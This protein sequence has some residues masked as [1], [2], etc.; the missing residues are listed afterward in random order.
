MSLFKAHATGNGCMRL[1]LA[2]MLVQRNTVPAC[3]FALGSSYGFLAFA[4][5]W[6]IIGS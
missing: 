5:G 1:I 6:G 2:R 3:R 4:E